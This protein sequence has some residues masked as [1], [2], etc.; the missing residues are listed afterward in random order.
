MDYKIVLALVVISG[1]FLFWYLRK[2]SSSGGCDD[3]SDDIKIM[4]FIYQDD[5]GHCQE[6]KPVWEQLKDKYTGQ[7]IVFEEID[8]KTLAT[9]FEFVPTLIMEKEGEQLEFKDERS[10]EKL[11][12]FLEL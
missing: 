1:L 8:N 2:G 7:S 12:K 6:F 3:K 11:S 9:P 10:L 4:R 5:C